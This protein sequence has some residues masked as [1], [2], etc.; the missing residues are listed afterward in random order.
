MALLVNGRGKTLV[1]LQHCFNT[2]DVIVPQ[3]NKAVLRATP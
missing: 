3:R 1:L 2:M